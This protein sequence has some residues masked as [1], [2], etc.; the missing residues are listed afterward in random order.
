MSISASSTE[1]YAPNCEGTNNTTVFV[2]IIRCLRWFTSTPNAPGGI[3]LAG[4]V[5]RAISNGRSLP[6][7]YGKSCRFLSPGSSTTSSKALG[8]LS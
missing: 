3:G 8:Q 7:L 1:S 4:V 6:I 5:I 2:V